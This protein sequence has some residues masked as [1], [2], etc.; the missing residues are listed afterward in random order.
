[1]NTP[2]FNVLV[3][4]I[5]RRSSIVLTK[6]RQEYAGDDEV[7]KNFKNGVGISIAKSPVGVAW[8]YNTK[9]IQSV[10]DIVLH[11]EET[12]K[13]P[14]YVT[15]AYLD[16]KFGDVNNYFIIMEGIIREMMRLRDLNAFVVQSPQ[17]DTAK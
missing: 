6:K 10:K 5:Q 11:I 16:E 3:D 17:I 7:F 4:D 2:D 9:H 15:S 14:D 12:G 8:D 13:L 1:M